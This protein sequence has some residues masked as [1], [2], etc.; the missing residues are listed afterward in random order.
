VAPHRNQDGGGH[1]SATITEKLTVPGLTEDESVTLNLLVQQLA[2]KQRR[3]QMRS[4]LYDGRN[5]V[6]QVG[7]V[8]PP[9]Y[10]DLALVL[11]WAAKGV[12]GL[13]NR[14]TLEKMVWTGGDIDALGMQQLEDSNYLLSELAMARTDSLIHGVS[15][16]VTTRGVEA[17][18][19]P[20]VLV[21]ARDAL[22]ASGEWNT[23]RRALD[24]LLSVTSWDDDRITGF[25][26]YLDNMTISATKTAGKW[27]I[28]RSEHTFGV[29]ADPLVYRPR[30]SR[31]MGR[32]RISRPAISIQNSALRA[33]VRAEAHMDIYAIPKMIL[34]GGSDAMFKN[35]DGSTKASWEVVMGRVFGIPDDDNPKNQN[36]RADVK[37]VNAESPAPHHA[38][39]N[40]QAKLIAREF[41]L[42]DQDFALTDMA[43]PTSEGSYIQGRDSLVAEAENATGAWS[44][45]IRRRVAAALAMQNGLSAVPESWKSMQPKWRSPLYLSKSQAAAAG[46]QQLSAV[47]WL[48]E[49][50]VGLELLGLDEQQI[51]RALVEKRRDAGRAVIAALANRQPVTPA[52]Q[53]NAVGA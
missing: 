21:H 20:P 26:L 28:Y 16:L 51:Q 31:R 23:R 3:N 30:G 14:C 4:N 29:P 41:D 2:D 22:H 25:V 7:G 52:P 33:L 50:E 46:A 36:P 49:T 42:P 27:S 45:P 32:S 24:A 44:I 37:T 5:A 39:L 15:Y 17:D 47:P 34:L 43:N 40:V 18:G 8:I 48:A 9:Q 6:R 12:D 1:V 19:E 11:G 35:P 38:Q 13:D 53:A 10:A